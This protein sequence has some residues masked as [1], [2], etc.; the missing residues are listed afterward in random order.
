MPPLR[1]RPYIEGAHKGDKLELD[2]DV[3]RKII[4]FQE[5]TGAVLIDA[6]AAQAALDTAS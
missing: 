5:L 4:R 1:K 6:K 2:E 3:V